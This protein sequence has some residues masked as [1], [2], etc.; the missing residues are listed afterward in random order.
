[1]ELRHLRYFVAVAE[2]LHFGRAALKLHI[3]QPPLSM[4]IKQL[5]TELGFPLFLRTSR[6]VELTQAGALFLN[7]SRETLAELERSIASA[8]RVARGESGWLGIGFVGSATYSVLPAVLQQ[9]R[10]V[11]PDVELVLRELVSAKQAQALREGRIHVGL[12]RPAIQENGIE[13]EVILNEP[14]LA[15]LPD[16]HPLAKMVRVRIEALAGVP[17]I[18][19]PRNP[20]P[21]YADFVLSICEQAGFVPNVVQE[22]AEMHTAIG[23]VAAGLGVTL[24]PESVR[25]ERRPGL[26]FRDLAHPAPIT[27]LTAAYRTSDSSPVLR[28]FLPI[29]RMSAAQGIQ[30]DAAGT[31][32]SRNMGRLNAIG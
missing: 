22:A 2:E 24:V 16:S 30:G 12:A 32:K 3:A 26:T 13:S 10:K 31:V 15:A 23:L 19:F 25:T 29:L 1:M 7:E 14:L 18:L 28:E 17:F 27:E 21:S 8:R 20:K 4:Q 9:F 6:K 11:R 5:E